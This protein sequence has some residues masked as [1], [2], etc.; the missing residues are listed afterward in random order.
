MD[1][2]LK[3]FAV[4]NSVLL[5]PHIEVR[6]VQ[7]RKK[8]SQIKFFK[9]FIHHSMCRKPLKRHNEWISMAHPFIL[10]NGQD[11]TLF[12]LFREDSGR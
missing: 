10:D 8:Q 4:L 6:T 1:Q 11:P 3:H 7:I 2:I 9:T 5:H 12:D